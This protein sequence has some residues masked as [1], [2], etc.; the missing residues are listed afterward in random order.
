MKTVRI[1]LLGCLAAVW[2]VACGQDTAEP[3]SPDPMNSLNNEGEGDIV[4]YSPVEVAVWKVLGKKPSDTTK[5]ELETVTHLPRV[6]PWTGFS[7]GFMEQDELDLLAACVN[8]VE[9]E[10]EVMQV[11]NEQLAVLASLTKLESLKLRENRITDLSPIAKLTN[12]KTLD[13]SANPIA[14][15]RLRPVIGLPNLTALNASNIGLTDLR[16]IADLVNLQQLELWAPDIDDLSPIARL[17]NLQSLRFSTG[18]IDDLT[19]F[20]GL[21]N[22]QHL[23]LSGNDIDNL[24]PLAGLISLQH[25]DLSGNDIDDLTPIVGLV[26]LETLDL[27]NNRIVDIQPLLDNRGIGAGD[28]I[29]LKANKLSHISRKQHVPALEARGVTVMW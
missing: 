15:L 12:L 11:S 26:Q 27:N 3:P 10:I 8:L 25:L 1:I 19:P 24:N 23:D 2:I 9:L 7:A 28:E 20:A 4:E 29:Q 18:D 6:A 13:I 14:D 5:E 21:I 22:L 16:P 17:V